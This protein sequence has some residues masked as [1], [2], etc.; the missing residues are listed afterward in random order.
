M[1]A[2]YIDSRYFE[3]PMLRGVRKSFQKQSLRT[4]LVSQNIYL[5]QKEINKYEK[6]SMKKTK[7][8]SNEKIK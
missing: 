2:R 7:I 4:G 5:E 3:I 1:V 6:L 8:N